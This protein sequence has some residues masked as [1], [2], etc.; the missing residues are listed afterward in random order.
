MASGTFYDAWG[1]TN[2]ATD[3]SVRYHQNHLKVTW[4]SDNEKVTYTVNAYARSGNGSGSHY[5]S[6]YG[7]TVTL[8]YSLNGGSWQSLGSV[9][10]TLNYNDN[11]ANIT[12]T[13]TI[14]RTHSS[15]TIK[16][17]AV[18]TGNYLNT[19]TTETGNDTMVVKPSYTVSY[20]ANGGSNAP[21]NQ[22]KWYNETLTL[23]TS[24][25]T[26]SGYSFKNWNTV[27]TPSTTTP[28]TSY[29]SGGSYTANA[30]TTLYAQWIVDYIDPTIGSVT[31]TR[32]DSS[33]QEQE[34]GTSAKVVITWSTDSNY[35]GSKCE[36]SYK[37]SSE[38]TYGTTITKNNL[39]GSSGTIEERIDGNFD[40]KK[41]YTIKVVLTDTHD[42]TAVNY[43]GVPV[44]FAFLQFLAGGT[45]IA[46]GKYASVPNK[47]ETTLPIIVQSTAIT[48]GV[49]PSTDINTKSLLFLDNNNNEI[50][51]CDSRF[52]I[53]NQLQFTRLF[54]KRTITINN[55]TNEYFNGIYIGL[56]NDGSPIVGLNNYNNKHAWQKAL[57]PDVLFEGATVP[58]GTSPA[59]LQLNSSAA[60]YNH[61]RIYYKSVDIL[62]PE[63]SVEVFN[64]NGKY[65]NLFTGYAGY[66]S[67]LYWPAATDIYINGTEITRRYSYQTNNSTTTVRTMGPG[68]DTTPL[69]IIYIEAW[70]D[71]WW[72]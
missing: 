19:A 9:Y 51:W 7:V 46:I 16:F 1:P 58:N 47:I 43:G 2:T 55:T 36:I 62:K 41:S 15:Q 70:N 20:N 64:P 14:N 39:S 56:K 18:N 12:K 4:S 32:C 30:A 29:L 45:G 8:Y 59:T 13:V 5:M 48:D 49:T 63:S 54:T 31:V 38:T 33:G 24:K 28:G 37:E 72:G 11:V 25:P 66:N 44:C 27:Q 69:Q 65:V 35:A 50:G 6:D 21:A 71:S 53:N 17:R 34:N 22:T 52:E 60:N 3:S 40:I 42:G 10:G 23:T 67:G 57:E 26:Y 61:M 68:G